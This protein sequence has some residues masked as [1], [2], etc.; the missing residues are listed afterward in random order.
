MTFWKAYP[1]KVKKQKSWEIWCK[2][3]PD[4][5]LVSVIMD[6]LDKQKRSDRWHRENGRYIPDPTT[7]LNGWRWEDEL[8]AVEP[9]RK[10]VREEYGWQ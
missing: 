8:P 6:A 9:E 1:K 5:A 3:R 10:P 7:W 4:A 2:L